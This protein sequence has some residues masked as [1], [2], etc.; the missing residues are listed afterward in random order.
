[1]NHMSRFLSSLE[2]D[3]EEQRVPK[4]AIYLRALVFGRLSDDHVVALALLHEL[5]GIYSRAYRTEQVLQGAHHATQEDALSA[6]L[7][8]LGL[9]CCLQELESSEIDA[10]ITC[11]RGRWSTLPRPF[12]SLMQRFVEHLEAHAK[13]ALKSAL[14]PST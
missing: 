6:H 3:P 9:P 8:R 5:G 10:L 4:A 11:W 2:A 1:M 12:S 14:L 13:P 7:Q